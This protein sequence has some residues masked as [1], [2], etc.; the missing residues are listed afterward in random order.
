MITVKKNNPGKIDNTANPTQMYWLDKAAKEGRLEECMN[1]PATAQLLKSLH[2]NG[3]WLIC[4][5]QPK[6]DITVAPALGVV[7]RQNSLF[8][9]NLPSRIAHTESCPFRYTKSE[10]SGDT[11]QIKPVS[12]PLNLHMPERVTSVMSG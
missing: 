3:L 8:L 12:G 4:D 10:G 11:G 9:R 6:A 1:H 5:C 7:K 2:E